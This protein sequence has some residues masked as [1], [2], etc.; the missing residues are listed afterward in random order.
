MKELTNVVYDNDRLTTKVDV[1][2]ITVYAEYFQ[3]HHDQF[4]W[5]LSMWDKITIPFYRVKRI[6]ID[7]YWEVR[8]GFQRMFNEFDSVDV[9]SMDTKFIQ[10][11]QKILKRYKENH[12]GYPNDMT[13]EEWEGIIDKM[14]FHLYYMD[15]DNVIKELE[16]VVP[17]GW[18]ASHKIVSEVMDKHKD[19]FFKLFSEYFFDLWD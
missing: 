19:E 9:F 16:G 8:Y 7:A 10:R 18:T 17:E 14:I 1:G 2:G 13:N 5:K 6:I 3:M 12:W 11:Y 4:D 15:E